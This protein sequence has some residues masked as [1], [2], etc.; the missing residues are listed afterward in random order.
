VLIDIALET[1]EIVGFR[2]AQGLHQRGR[3]VHQLA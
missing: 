3:D 1:V 2:F